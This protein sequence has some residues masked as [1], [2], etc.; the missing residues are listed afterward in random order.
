MKVGL[1][2]AS[3][4]GSPLNF[5]QSEFKVNV[6]RIPAMVSGSP[7]KRA[8]AAHNGLKRFANGVMMAAAFAGIS[9]PFA[10]CTNPAGGTTPIEKPD[11]GATISDAAKGVGNVYSSVDPGYEIV[12]DADAPGGWKELT[13]ETQGN[14]EKYTATAHDATTKQ[15]TVDYTSTAKDT[16]ALLDSKTGLIM[17]LNETGYTLTYPS[18]AKQNF[19]TQTGAA[20]ERDNYTRAGKLN[21]ARA[22]DKG[23]ADAVAVAKDGIEIW[24]HVTLKGTKGLYDYLLAKGAKLLKALHR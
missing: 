6:N 12:P 3:S 22:F 1:V 7:V 15:Y 17:T 16:G 23:S 8:H 13:Y 18:G 9:L 19:I 24:D 20:F 14:I 21:L 4:V 11:P 2:S 5:G 10:S